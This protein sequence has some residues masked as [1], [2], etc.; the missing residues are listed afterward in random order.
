MNAMNPTQSEMIMARYKR[1]EREADDLGRVIGVR[2][3]RPSEQTK[4]TGMTPDLA[5]SGEHIT[6]DGVK[7][8]VPDRLP[9]AIAAAVCEINS[10]PIPF[11]RTRGELDAVFDML[12]AE[13]LAAASRALAKLQTA[14]TQVDSKETAKN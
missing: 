3:L 8:F 9:L 4:L 5:G 12:D 7:H 2:K 1:I 14:E 6:P 10:A 13:G 11:P